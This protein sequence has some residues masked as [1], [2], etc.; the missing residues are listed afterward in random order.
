MFRENERNIQGTFRI[1][2]DASRH[3][4][5]SKGKHRRSCTD[6]LATRW[7]VVIRIN[8]SKVSALTSRVYPSKTLFLFIGFVGVYTLLPRLPSPLSAVIYLANYFIASRC[9]SIRPVGRVCTRVSPERIPISIYSFAPSRNAKTFS[10][11]PESPRSQE[12]DAVAR[13]ALRYT[14][15]SRADA[16]PPR[17]L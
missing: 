12:P 13:N 9:S 11:H 4:A 7:P 14:S 1:D 5:F 2:E 16:L 6:L 3:I 15:V 8:A 17:F 10:F